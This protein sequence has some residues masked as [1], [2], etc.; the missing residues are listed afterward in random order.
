MTRSWT[1]AALRR[2][3]L[4]AVSLDA[5]WGLGLEASRLVAGVLTFL[6]LGRIL[7]PGPY[8][9]YIAIYAVL[10]MFTSL[11][12]AALMLVVLQASVRDGEPAE[13]V[14]RSCLTWC[15]ITGTVLVA[16]AIASVGAVVDTASLATV[17]AFAVSE[18]LV[19]GT[20][21]I[22]TQTYMAATS[23]IAAAQVRLVGI[24]ARLAPVLVLALTGRLSLE[25][26][27]IANG[28]TLGLFAGWLHRAVRARSGLLLGP[29]R[30]EVRHARLA[31]FFVGPMLA[32][33]LFN[34]GDKVVLR[35]TEPEETVGRY[36]AAYR[37][38]GIVLLPLSALVGSS[39]LRFLEHDERATGQ[40]VRRALRFTI[41]GVLYAVPA[42]LVLLIAAPAVPVVLGHEFAGTDT[43]VRWLVA[44]VVV[45]SGWTF[46]MNGLLGLGR[47]ALRAVLQTLSASLSLILYLTFIPRWGWQGAAVAT[48][49]SE[50]VLSVATWGVLLRAQRRHDAGVVTA[51]VDQPGP[52]PITGCAPST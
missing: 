42:G 33:A 36:S 52:S 5:L 8:G 6:L 7:G 16:A 44:F 39:Y 2:R 48:L 37:L 25:S 50:T 23:F 41:A 17:A 46:A 31:G 30:P 10:G 28:V 35:S 15:W 3:N 27:A 1:V 49:V 4:R 13:R 12:Y 21:E 47:L 43:M 14:G 26:L 51:E 22:T 32:F 45:R 19:A 18:M 29:G 24:A 34:D 9:D 40:H 20:I 11:A 38:V